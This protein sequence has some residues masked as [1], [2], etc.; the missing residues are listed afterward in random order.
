MADRIFEFTPRLTAEELRESAK[1]GA[2]SIYL[3]QVGV[4]LCLNSQEL[5]PR[6]NWKEVI[7]L[8]TCVVR[9]QPFGGEEAVIRSVATT[10]GAGLVKLGLGL[11]APEAVYASGSLFVYPLD[12]EINNQRKRLI[13][14]SDGSIFFRSSERA[15][16]E[17]KKAESSITRLDGFYEILTSTLGE[18]ASQ[19]LIRG[20]EYRE[21]YLK[22]LRGIPHFSNNNTG[23]HSS[24]TNRMF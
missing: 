3:E 13:Q 17:I 4:G 6:I 5:E 1:G 2:S 12:K 21:Q 7:G 16:E 10:F 18:Y 22:M 24:V 8:Y 9:R 15:D 11:G 19:N 20:E 23:L 14:I